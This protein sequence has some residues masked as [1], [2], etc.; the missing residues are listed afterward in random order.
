VPWDVLISEVAVEGPKAKQLSQLSFQVEAESRE[1][2]QAVAE[3]RRDAEFAGRDESAI[4]IDVQ[5]WPLV[6]L[7]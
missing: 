3:E 2:A 1:P 6:H 5:P 4:L 7:N